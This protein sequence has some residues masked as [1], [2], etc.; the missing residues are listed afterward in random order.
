MSAMRATI[1]TAAMATMA[2]VEAATITHFFL[3][4]S[5]LLKTSFARAPALQTSPRSC[6]LRNW[7]LHL[8]GQGWGMLPEHSR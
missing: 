8:D 1:T 7:A 3:S 4:C 6:S 2:T 5:L